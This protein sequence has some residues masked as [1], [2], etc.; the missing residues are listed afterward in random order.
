MV[1]RVIGHRATLAPFR[2][3]LHLVEVEVYL[4]AL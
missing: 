1:A 4:P 2:D 3:L